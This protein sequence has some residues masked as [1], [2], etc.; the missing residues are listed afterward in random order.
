MSATAHA[1]KPLGEIGICLQMEHEIYKALLGIF[2][3]QKIPRLNKLTI[4]N[5]RLCRLHAPASAPDSII[6]RAMQ[7]LPDNI[8]ENEVLNSTSAT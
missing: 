7:P 3:T 2:Y 8:I 1:T 4:S 6:S 5:H